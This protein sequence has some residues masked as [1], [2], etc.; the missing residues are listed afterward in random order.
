METKQPRFKA[1]LNGEVLGWYDSLDEAQDAI[2]VAEAQDEKEDADFE[3]HMMR[4]A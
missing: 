3:S 1:T 2:A 4:G